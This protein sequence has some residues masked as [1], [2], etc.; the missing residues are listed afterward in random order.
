MNTV[1]NRPEDEPKWMKGVADPTIYWPS[2]DP[3]IPAFDLQYGKEQYCYTIWIDSY[4]QSVSDLDLFN[5]VIYAV[6]GG[7]KIGADGVLKAGTTIVSEILA[8]LT[9]IVVPFF[10]ACIGAM[11]LAIAISIIH[12]LVKNRPSPRNTGPDREL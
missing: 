2:H 8:P 5:A 4:R 12:K 10:Y 1:C 11:G 7:L 3:I 6:G 9:A